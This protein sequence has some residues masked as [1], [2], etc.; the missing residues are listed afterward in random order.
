[1]ASP[2]SDK[3]NLKKRDKKCQLRLRKI[4]QYQ[5]LP[6]IMITFFADRKVPTKIN[7]KIYY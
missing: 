3:D 4:I 5:V 6:T 1:M 2:L 7:Q